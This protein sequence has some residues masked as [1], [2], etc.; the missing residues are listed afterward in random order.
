MLTNGN[1]EDPEVSTDPDEWL[2][3]DYVHEQVEAMMLRQWEA[4]ERW[5]HRF[6]QI[7]A[8]AS[9][10]S[11][12]GIVFLPE[13]IGNDPLATV[14]MFLGLAGLIISCLVTLFR[15]FPKVWQS[16]PDP[17][18]LR[19]KYLTTD[20]RELRLLVTDT[21]IESFEVNEHHLASNLTWFRWSVSLLVFG[22]VCLVAASAISAILNGT[23]AST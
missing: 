15:L 21:R 7:L 10:L 6:G 22:L 5:D 18:T 11:V 3:L 14:V 9:A 16:A 4:S 2:S 23:D 12:A 13:K 17:R 20:P 8:F 19:S 1:S